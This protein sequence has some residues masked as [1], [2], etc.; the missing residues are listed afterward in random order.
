MTPPRIGAETAAVVCHLH[1]QGRGIRDIARALGL[2]RN[3]VRRLLRAPTSQEDAAT[4]PEPPCSPEQLERID[5]ALKR[6]EGNA[7]RAQEILAAEHGLDLA[8]STLTRWIREGQLRGKPRRAGSYHFEPGEESQH[9][10][11]PHWV[12]LGGRRRKLQC[13]SLTLAFSRYLFFQYYPRFT[14]FEAKAFLAD[15][16]AYCEGS[17][18][19]VTIDN[20]SVIVGIGT[21][22]EA[23]IAPEMVAFG[24]AYGVTFIAHRVHHPDR[25]AR[26]ERP[27]SYIER[28]FLAGRE[29][30]DFEDLNVQARAWCTTYANAKVKRALGMSPA[31]AHQIE[32]P[33]LRALPAAPPP[34]FETDER[35]VD[36]RGYVTL[37]TNRY[38]VPERFVGQHVTVYKYLEHIRITHR[39]RTIAEHPRLIDQRD[40]TRTVAEH[41]PTPVRTV[42]RA[43]PVEEQQLR[44]DDPRLDR[45]L[46]EIKRRGPGRGVRALRRLLELKRSYP[47]TPFLEAVEVALHYGLYDLAR[48]ESL[49]LRRI[50]GEFFDLDTSEADDE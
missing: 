47:R 42:R 25:K 34:V 38:S 31:E 39:E 18:E 14:R 10:T 21:G 9:D 12:H 33:S 2:S 29:F 26:V 40:G 44:G 36:I 43:V 32:K 30:R 37:E 45:Y 20:T 7:V 8:Y 13:T 27:F 5:A 22:P 23:I 24:A 16:F 17:C 50:A 35:I 6:A 28:N 1:R 41:H 11:S 19:R 48:L 49:I 15:A 3:T 4:E 46:D